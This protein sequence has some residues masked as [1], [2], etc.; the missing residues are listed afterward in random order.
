MT[1]RERIVEAARA[2]FAEGGLDALSARKVA[3]AVGLSPMALYRHFAS[4]DALVDALVLDG[5]EAWRARLEAT[6]QAEPVHWLAAAGDAFLD[7]ALEEPRRFEAAFLLRA[8]AARR[9]PEDF[10]DGRSPPVRL[11]TDQVRRAQAQGAL[12][13]VAPEEIALSIWAMAQGLVSLWRAGRF[14]DEAAFREVY[15]R[16]LRRTLRSFAVTETSPP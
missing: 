14:S 1:T 9:Y 10:R 15:R 4:M 5:L 2:I 13:D 8:A 7:F 16:A 11:L 3:S 12:E 6:A